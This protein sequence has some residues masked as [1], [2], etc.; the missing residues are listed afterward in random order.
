[1]QS[2][3]EMDDQY[4][5]FRH[6][7]QTSLP[8]SQQ[9][10]PRNDI[11]VEEDLDMDA[12]LENVSPERRGNS[13]QISLERQPIQAA[14]D[15]SQK[16]DRITDNTPPTLQYRNPRIT[17]ASESQTTKRRKAEDYTA[18]STPHVS[19]KHHTPT[20]HTKSKGTSTLG[21]DMLSHIWLGFQMHEDLLIERGKSTL[22]ESRTDEEFLAIGT[23]PTEVQ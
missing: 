1:M 18:T 19:S 7:I 5:V 17:E 15:M 11:E 21:I 9:I 8:M 10:P 6:Q 16:S 13:L 22:K 2:P 3:N 23:P 20:S 12:Q 14:Q 4:M